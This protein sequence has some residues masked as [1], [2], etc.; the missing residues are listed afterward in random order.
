MLSVL[1]LL[2]QLWCSAVQLCFPQTGREVPTSRLWC[3]VLCSVL[4][5]GRARRGEGCVVLLRSA[6]AWLGGPER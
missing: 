2:C 3:G 1:S 5:G 4:W 6:G